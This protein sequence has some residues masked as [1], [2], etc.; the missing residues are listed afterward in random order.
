MSTSESS[1]S[2]TEDFSI[3]FKNLRSSLRNLDKELEESIESLQRI[4]KTVK[5]TEK[6]TTPPDLLTEYPDLQKYLTRL[7]KENRLSHNGSKVLLNKKDAHKFGLEEGWT[8]VYK[9]CQY[10]KNN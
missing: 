3:S 7:K 8:S 9:I 2:D 4:R 1:D 10:L 5:H 6:H